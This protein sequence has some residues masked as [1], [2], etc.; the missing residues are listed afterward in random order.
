MDQ[1]GGWGGAVS[2]VS[3]RRGRKHREVGRHSQGGRMNRDLPN[4]PIASNRSASCT[5][6]NSTLVG[7]HPSSHSPFSLSFFSFDQLTEST[8][9]QISARCADETICAASG[10]VKNGSKMESVVTGS[11][12]VEREYFASF[13][14]WKRAASSRT[15]MSGCG[16]EEEVGSERARARAVRRTRSTGGRG[17]GRSGELARR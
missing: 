4:P 14:S 9:R 12:E 7:R 3:P 6:A 10:E 16:E 11:P 1:E 15:S 5:H 8:T 2:V 17:R 13:M